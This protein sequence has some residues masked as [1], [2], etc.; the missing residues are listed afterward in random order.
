MRRRKDDCRYEIRYNTR[1]GHIRWVEV[2]AQ[3]SLD[4]DYKI[5]GT[6]GTLTDITQR[7]EGGSGPAAA[8]GAPPARA[9]FGGTGA[10]G[11][12]PGDRQ[13][14]STTRT[15]PSCS[16]TSAAEIEQNI[17]TWKESI[18]PFDL[19]FVLA[20]L[21]AHHEEKSKFFDVEYRAQRKT[22]DVGLVQC[23]GPR[24]RTRREALPA[25]DD[26]HHR[27]YQPAQ[28]SRGGEPAGEPAA[29]P[30]ERRLARDQREAAQAGGGVRDAGPR[31]LAHGQRRHTLGY[32]G[33]DHLGQPRV[34]GRDG[35]QLDEAI[36]KKP[37]EILRARPPTPRPG[38]TCA[39]N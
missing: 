22:G 13:A 30:A 36:G 34:P 12:G 38:G 35:F 31:R 16:V 6:T 3:P 15:G 33:E 14:L 29:R 17:E 39:S 37:G 5:S 7:K 2:Y 23:A 27:E 11:L 4:E 28:G 9:R 19:N 8:P 21:K 10:L 32:R 25:A 1:G 20:A 18:H 24:H 26:R